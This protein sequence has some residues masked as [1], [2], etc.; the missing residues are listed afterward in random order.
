MSAAKITFTKNQGTEGF[1][2]PEVVN[3]TGGYT[4]SADS[5]YL[6]YFFIFFIFFIFV[7]FFF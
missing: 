4:S 2:A 3:N 6:F 7:Y 1:M 5:N